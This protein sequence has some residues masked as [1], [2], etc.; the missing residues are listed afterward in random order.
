MKIPNILVT[1]ALCI[2]IISLFISLFA[3][4]RITLNQLTEEINKDKSHEIIEE[5][6]NELERG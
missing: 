3:A 1:I 4:V 2:T 5:W 6:R